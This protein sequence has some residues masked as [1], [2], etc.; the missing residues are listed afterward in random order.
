MVTEVRGCGAFA[1]VQNRVPPTGA[2]PEHGGD[3]G[4]DSLARILGAPLRLQPTPRCEPGEWFGARR[5]RRKRAAGGAGSRCSGPAGQTRRGVF[6]SWDFFIRATRSLSG[7]A[8]GGLGFLPPGLRAAAAAQLLGFASAP[9]CF[10]T[11]AQRPPPPAALRD[12]AGTQ[13]R[14]PSCGA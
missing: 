14:R 3:R 11:S 1:G 7:S 2:P 6:I 13:G 10:Q 12:S 4:P 9:H 8:L 5:G